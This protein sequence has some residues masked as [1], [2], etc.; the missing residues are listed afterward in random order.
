MFASASNARGE[1]VLVT[2]IGYELARF[3]AIVIAHLHHRARLLRDGNK[4]IVDRFR[5]HRL[6]QI[7]VD[8]KPHR[9]DDAP[10]FAV[11][12]QHDD[13]HIRHRKYARRAHDAHQFGPA[14]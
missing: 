7:F 1:R 10:A 4:T 5:R 2:A 14:Q 8:A 11:P 3:R 9:F 12:G 6:G 13:R